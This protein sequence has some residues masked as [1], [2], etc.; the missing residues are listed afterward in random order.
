MTFTPQV[1]TQTDNNNTILN[2]TDASFN[3]VSTITTGYNTL[4]LTITS[5]TDSLAGGPASP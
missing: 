5:T 3:G 4:I 2:S 1:L